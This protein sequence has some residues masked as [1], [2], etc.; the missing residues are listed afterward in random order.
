VQSFK[1]PAFDFI[2]DS[3]NPQMAYAG[4]TEVNFDITDRLTVIG[5]VRYSWERRANKGRVGIGRQPSGPLI[6]GP[7]VKFHAWTPRLSVSTS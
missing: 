3:W 1:N 7:T 6:I 5:G 4:F 2:F